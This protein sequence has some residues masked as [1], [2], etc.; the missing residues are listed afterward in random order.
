MFLG[1]QIS[2]F[3]SSSRESPFLLFY[4]FHKNVII[5]TS[6]KNPKCQTIYPLLCIT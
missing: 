4:N 6:T 5:L 3:L 2:P 1:Y